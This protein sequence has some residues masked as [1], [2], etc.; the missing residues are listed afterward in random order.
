MLPVKARH[1]LIVHFFQHQNYY[2]P[3]KIRTGKYIDAVTTN[4]QSFLKGEFINLSLISLS[5]KDNFDLQDS[6]KEDK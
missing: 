3:E 5:L 4:K 2:K 1:L 6:V